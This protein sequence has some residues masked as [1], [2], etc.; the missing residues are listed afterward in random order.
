MT[1]IISEVNIKRK[2]TIIINFTLVICAAC[3]GMYYG[4]DCSRVCDCEVE[5]VVQTETNRS[6]DGMTGHCTCLPEWTG[7]RCNQTVSSENTDDKM[8]IIIISSATV[9]FLLLVVVITVCVCK[10]RKS[11]TK[12]RSMMGSKFREI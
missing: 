11:D 3:E 2:I 5:H 1:N 6:C 8:L 12:G 9:G 4:R 10:F 7:S